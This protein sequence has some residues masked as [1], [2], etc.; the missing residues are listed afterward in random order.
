MKDFKSKVRRIY[1]KKGVVK[2]TSKCLLMVL[3]RLGIFRFSRKIV[4]LLDL[5]NLT[6]SSSRVPSGLTF[7]WG[8]AEDILK[9]DA[10]ILDYD[11]KGKEY[12]L[13]RLRSNDKFLMGLLNGEVVGY[14]WMMPGA[15]ELNMRRHF[16]LSENM[17][18]VYKAFIQKK[19]RGKNL[20]IPSM[21]YILSYL[22]GKGYRYVVTCVYSPVLGALLKRRFGFE[23]LGEIF[24]FSC[25]GKEVSVM[26]KDVSEKLE[27]FRR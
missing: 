12:S 22:R 17:V 7:R 5:A 4:C 25:L 2:G 10:K 15:M 23:R 24:E 1:R 20:I 21:N 11:K 8:E 9:M 26:S 3:S 6:L 16:A 19:F 14:L 27:R 13:A 18:Y